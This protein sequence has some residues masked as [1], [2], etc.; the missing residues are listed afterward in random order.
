MKDSVI[1]SVDLG[2]SYIKTGAYDINSNC[3]AG[4]SEPVMYEKPAPD[5]FLQYGD[6]LFQ[7]V[8]N[9]IK[10]TAFELKG[11]ERQI[12]AISF[13]GQMA[14]FMGV[15]AN[16]NDIT[17][18]SCSLD[19]R[20]TPYAVRQQEKLSED[21]LEISGTNAPLMCAKY[22]WFK[23]EFPKKASKIAKYVMISGYVIGRLGE[24]PIDDATIDGSYITWSGMGDVKNKKWSR[25]IC[26]EIGILMKFLPKVVDS[27][28]I[29]GR[30][31]PKI[32][33]KLGLKSGIPLVSGAGDK[34]AGC[35]GAG[36]L[37]YGDMIFEASSYGGFS[38]M[39]KDFRPD[40]EEHYFDIITSTQK[41]DFYA[42]KYI[43][44]SGITLDWFVDNFV[45]N[46][47]LDKKAA[48]QLIDEL[49]TQVEPG[50]DGVLAIGLLGGSAIPFDS[51]LKGLWMGHNWSHSKGHFYRALLESFSYDLALT[52]DR[53]ALSYPEYNLDSVKLIGG[54]AKSR[55]WA[56]ILA[57]VTGKQFV[58]IDREDAA[59]WGTA[60]LA[61]NAVGMFDD[62]KTISKSHVGIRET[63]EP[64]VAIHKKYRKY[65]Q[66]YKEFT[67]EFHD[68]YI[69]LE[70]LRT[71]ES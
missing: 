24:V 7:S 20:Y 49:A 26:D 51:V 41:E 27:N 48:F 29:C 61:G 6:Q 67:R 52:I 31:S 64:D 47:G 23:T 36:I 50:S 42:H 33:K 69:R 44:G 35:V 10:K 46:Q 5:V 12:E 18:W 43:Q 60:V 62:I 16:W 2:T 15:D 25:K 39:V 45:A 30:L 1:L 59:L 19:T 38:C 8:V 32:A 56:Q 21:F 34:V 54:G 55:L 71:I 65:K 70:R 63:F 28:T 57:D 9:C 3:I 53:I 37:D 17:T 13:T 22:D 66:L 68:Y 40:K 4:A 58:R 14:G 11:R